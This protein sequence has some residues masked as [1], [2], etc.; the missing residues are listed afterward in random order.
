MDILNWIYLK[1]EELIRP[2]A[3]DPSTD[4][5]ALGANVGWQKRG[6]SYQTYA[7]TPEGLVPLVYNK[8]NVTQITSAT[9]AVTVNA[10]SG[11]IT[12]VALTNAHDVKTTFTVNNTVITSASNILV[13]VNYDEAATGIP[14]ASIS[15]VTLGSFKLTV[16]N[17][18]TTAALN[19][20][21]K[22]SFIVLD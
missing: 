1:K 6:D 14:V 13:S 2:K 16:S 17:A 22:I 8:A 12:T 10:H 21:V 19:A 15:D 7:M 9:T 3:N 18:H 11:I 5:I 20:L 4:L